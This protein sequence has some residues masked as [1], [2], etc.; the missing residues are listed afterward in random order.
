MIIKHL[1]FKLEDSYNKYGWEFL[2]FGSVV[3]I[4]I[5]IIFNRNET[6]TYNEKFV[7]DGG[8]GEKLPYHEQEKKESKGENV[9]RNVC[10][11]I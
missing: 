11:K 1:M 6:G 3:F 10:Q 9:T 5:C 8:Q 7:F 4:I 2:L